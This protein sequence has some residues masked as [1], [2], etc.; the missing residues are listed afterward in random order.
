M[1]EKVPDK[2]KFSVLSIYFGIVCKPK[3]VAI[4]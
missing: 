4:Y 2:A 1:P 3:N